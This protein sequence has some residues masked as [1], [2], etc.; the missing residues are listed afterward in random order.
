MSTD[1]VTIGK[2]T[3]KKGL[4][5]KRL[6]DPANELIALAETYC[7]EQLKLSN[8]TLAETFNLPEA[9]QKFEFKDIPQKVKVVLNEDGKVEKLFFPLMLSI[10]Y[11]LE[12][13]FILFNRSY[14]LHGVLQGC[15]KTTDIEAEA[16]KSYEM[17]QVYYNKVTSIKVEHNEG[18]WD[19][20]SPK[21]CA[22]SGDFLEKYKYEQD[23][24]KIRCGEN[25]DIFSSEEPKEL[26]DCRQFLMEKIDAQ[27]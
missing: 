18:E 12:K 4:F 21:G 10:I 3:T 14:Y 26:R 1:N 24:M 23:G 22:C 19:V 25:F 15:S 2:I 16:S 6:L 11:C 27:Q 13:S 20:I 7:S 17:E 9:Y 5:S 8:E